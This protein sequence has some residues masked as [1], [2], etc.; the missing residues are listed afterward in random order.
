MW[1]QYLPS[2][3]SIRQSRFLSWLG[4]SIQQPYLWHPN[5]RAVARGVAIGAFFGLMIPVAQIPVAAVI[6]F[7]LRANLWV[8]A[9]ATLITNPLTF[10]PLYYFAYQ[11]GVALLGVPEPA[12]AEELAA[13]ATSVLE[14]FGYWWDRFLT[15]GQPLLL[16]LLLMAVCTSVTGYFVTQLLWRARVRIKRRSLRIRRARRLRESTGGPAL[17]TKP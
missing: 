16:G 3:E 4:P 8:S 5:R 13:R 12:T 10:G 7:F 11:I 15:H 9:T 1:K 17:E 2:A 14:W 6:A